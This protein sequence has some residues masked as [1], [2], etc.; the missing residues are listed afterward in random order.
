LA[1]P[2]DLQLPIALA[3]AAVI[4]GWFGTLAYVPLALLPQRARVAVIER[5]HVQSVIV[6]TE[7]QSAAREVR[8]ASLLAHL[9]DADPVL[10]REEQLRASAA[11]V[12]RLQAAAA[13][14]ERMPMTADERARWERLRADEVPALV[15]SLRNLEA[16]PTRAPGAVLAVV[17]SGAAV[18]EALG[19]LVALNADDAQREA[20]QLEGRLTKLSGGY[21]ALA[22]VGT[23]GAVVLL[24]LSLRA[25]RRYQEATRRQVAELEAFAGQ[26]SHDLRSPLQTVQLAVG[27]LSRASGDPQVQ[28]LAE[29]ALAGVRR[30]DGMIG[31]LLQFARAGATWGE[32]RADVREVLASAKER[33]RPLAERTGVELT[34]DEGAAQ[35]EATIDLVAGI[36]PVAL[37]TVV[38][39]LVENAIK[40]R[41]PDRRNRVEVAAR[42][43]GD[44]V[45]LTV[46]DTG[47]GIPPDLLPRIFEPF[48]Q[49]SRRPD[50]YGL[51][52]AAVKRLVEAHRGTVTAASEEGRGTTFTVDLPRARGE[53][54]R[55]RAPGSAA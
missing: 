20:Q 33:L 11:A 6:L 27:A 32:G 4:V 23:V 55:E 30:L 26:V 12:A 37:E 47:V 43:V 46:A 14:Y 17:R 39:N 49:G 22:A 3:F 41:K 7:M 54:M 50:S 52:L 24:V 44:R 8:Q 35:G 1:R 34:F 5:N 13:G 31:D 10:D 2:T 9:A 48:V 18:D 40:Y 36:A 21:A 29:R 53:P 42:A 25:L 28:R 38:A 51:G 16:G 19:A 15:S 45:L